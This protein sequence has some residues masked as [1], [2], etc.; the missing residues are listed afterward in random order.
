MQFNARATPETV[1]ALYAIADRQGWLVG[2]TLEHALAALQRELVRDRSRD[3]SP[4]STPSSHGGGGFSGGPDEANLAAN[5][6]AE[7]EAG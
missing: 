2:K 5:H 4:P 3:L 6:F 7:Y 1:E